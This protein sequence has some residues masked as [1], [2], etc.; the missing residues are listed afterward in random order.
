MRPAGAPC[1]IGSLPK[2]YHLASRRARYFVAK[3]LL[4]TGLQFGE[5]P[6]PK[7]SMGVV[8][9]M[10]RTTTMHASVVAMS[11]IGNGYCVPSKPA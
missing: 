3:I 9:P 11:H 6:V 2:I 8:S 10:A 1:A 5:K 4:G 7:S